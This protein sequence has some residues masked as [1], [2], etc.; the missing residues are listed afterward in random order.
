MRVLGATEEECTDTCR[1]QGQL[2]ALAPGGAAA[3][4]R[5]AVNRRIVCRC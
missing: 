3:A 5:R 4:R 2:Q 1:D